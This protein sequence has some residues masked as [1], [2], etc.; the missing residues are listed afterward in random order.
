MSV[1]VRELQLAPRSHEEEFIRRYHFLF[2]RCLQL[3]KQKDIA[4]DLLHDGFVQFTI[5]RPDLG[6]IEDL[7]GYLCRLLRNLYY[8]RLRLATWSPKNNLSLIDYDSAAM[9]LRGRDLCAEIHV[10]QDLLRICR[11]A[12][13]RKET[14]KKACILTL[15]YFHG[16]YPS[17]IAKIVNSNGLL[18][19]QL[20]FDA[21]KEVKRYLTNSFEDKSAGIELPKELKKMSADISD[22]QFLARLRQA[23]FLHKNGHCIS[24]AELKALYRDSKVLNGTVLA[25]VVHCAGCLDQINQLRGLPP[26]SERQAENGEGRERP[27]RNPGGNSGPRNSS[28]SARTSGRLAARTREALEHLPAELRIVVNGIELGGQS[29][30]AA[31]NELRLTVN[32]TQKITFIEIYSELGIRLLFM[33]VETFPDGPIEQ[34]Q[35]VHLS[36]GRT[37]EA[38]LRFTGSLPTLEVTYHDPVFELDVLEEGEPVGLRPVLVPLFAQRVEDARRVREAFKYAVAWSE[39]VFA[40]LVRLFGF[41]SKAQLHFSEIR[42]LRQSF[43]S[44]EVTGRE[45]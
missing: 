39:E 17:E 27:P 43:L 12:F 21:R 20:L 19:R 10:Q 7:D 13:I 22:T 40:R 38:V 3:T 2:S 32:L 9:A 41:G 15:R 28:I 14:S 35:G 23:L 26:L 16:Y 8:A 25:H 29:I 30:R 37:L 24:P 45:D 1:A 42:G 33:D 44:Q 5:N 31:F 4:E 11:Y 18:V 6:P 34:K 36:D